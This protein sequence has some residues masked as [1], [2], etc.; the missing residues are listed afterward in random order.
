MK[1]FLLTA[2]L[3]LAL[4]T[5]LTAGTMAY[6][7]ATLPT[8]NDEIIT[9]TFSISAGK[10]AEFAKVVQLAPGDNAVYKIRVD[11]TGEVPAR[12][13]VAASLDYLT[14]IPGLSV[15]VEVE[16]ASTL[17]MVALPTDEDTADIDVESFVMYVVTVSWAE[18]LEWSPENTIA[19]MGQTIDLSIAI[20]A[21]QIVRNDT[22]SVN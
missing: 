7:T 8:I 13:T 18:G 22:V 12:T 17:A 5:S 14:T 2:A 6:Y 15:T 3:I 1:K 9:K 19:W 21:E 20:N 10:T 4:V 11:N 16:D